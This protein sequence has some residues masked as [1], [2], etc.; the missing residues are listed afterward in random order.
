[1]LLLGVLAA[2][3]EAAAGAASDYDLLE[4]EI[5]TGVQA[6][7]TFSSLNSTYGSTYSHLQIRGVVQTT[8]SSSLDSLRI[9]VNSDTGSNYAYHFIQGGNPPSLTS[10]NASS[11]TNIFAGYS[12]GIT[13]SYSWEPV[14]IDILDAFNTNKYSTFRYLSGMVDPNW[15]LPMF[16]SGLW[17]NTN[18][19]DEIK[20]FPDVGGAFSIGTRLSLYG[21]RS[22]TT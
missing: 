21:L 3:A 4:S 17:M 19:L 5:L 13:N 14:V 11:Q 9:Q 2:Q 18:A 7:V 10:G 20:L 8:R 12:P 22:V 1:M 16:G 15:Q 6:S